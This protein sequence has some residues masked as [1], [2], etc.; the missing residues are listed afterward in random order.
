MAPG[1]CGRGPE[2]PVGRLAGV[3]VRQFELRV[4]AVGLVVAWTVVAL[5][6]LV[7]YRPGGPLDLIVG[8]TV[9]LPIAI[10]VAAVIW[11][12]LARGA[13]AFPLMLALG[14]GSLLVLLPSIAGVADQ[15]FALGS[16]TLLPSLVR[17]TVFETCD[18]R[19]EYEGT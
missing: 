8:I 14:I 1:T 15:I 16:Q 18:A 13:G 12:P 19:C 10:A 5:L 2:A 9:L 4:I 7:A 6:V 11:P 3:R 17:V